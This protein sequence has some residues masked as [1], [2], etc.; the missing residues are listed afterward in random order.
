MAW[1]ESVQGIFFKKKTSDEAP[2]AG[3]RPGSDKASLVGVT[4]GRATSTCSYMKM[5]GIPALHSSSSSFSAFFQLFS[6]FFKFYL[7]YLFYVIQYIIASEPNVNPDAD[8][9]PIFKQVSI[10]DRTVDI[11]VSRLCFLQFGY[12]AG[13]ISTIYRYLCSGPVLIPM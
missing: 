10:D 7:F 9:L 12:N 3:V 2:G 13:D 1:S 5:Q 6:L 11:D 8:V 4:L